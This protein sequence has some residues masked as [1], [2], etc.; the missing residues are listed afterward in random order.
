M[1]HCNI[2]KIYFI[3]KK[4]RQSGFCYNSSLFLPHLD[5]RGL[6]GILKPEESASFSPVLVK[7]QEKLSTYRRLS[8]P[9]Q[10][11]AFAAKS[12]QGWEK[13]FWDRHLISIAIKITEYRTETS[14][15]E[16]STSA[17]GTTYFLWGSIQ[18]MHWKSFS[19]CIPI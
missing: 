12:P 3:R 1:L 11:S 2:S 7:C 17:Q 5:G 14:L 6:T 18:W 13:P 4:W 10:L 15:C 9:W 16:N 8:D 19:K